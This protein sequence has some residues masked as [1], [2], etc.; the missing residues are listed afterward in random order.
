MT[1]QVTVD[2][3]A[4]QKE[5]LQSLKISFSGDVM[6]EHCPQTIEGV[7]E[8]YRNVPSLIK[9]LNDGKGK[10]L[11]FILYPLQRIAEMFNFELKMKR[12]I[13][14]VSEHIIARIENIFEQIN[15]GKRQFN[16]FLDDI[17]PWEQFI[18]RDWLC[19][20]KEKKL[21]LDGDAL[22]TQREMS[23]LLVEIRSGSAEESKMKELL[24]NFDSQNP[25]SLI[26]DGEVSKVDFI[27]E[28]GKLFP[29]GNPA[30]YCDYA[31]S[32][33]D[34]DKSGTINFSE[35]M[36][37]VAPTQPGD[38]EMRLSVIF[39]VCD[40]DHSG[41]INASEIVKFIEAIEELRGGEAA[42]NTTRA[43]S[44]AAEIMN[45]SGKSKDG[46]VTKEEFIKCSKDNTKISV[47]LLSDIT[48]STPSTTSTTVNDEKSNWYRMDTS[49]GSV[50][51]DDGWARPT[52]SSGQPTLFRDVLHQG[53]TYIDIMTGDYKGYYL[54]GHSQKG[55]GAWSW[56]G[57]DYMEWNNDKLKS[58]SGGTKGHDMAYG[59][60]DRFYFS[61]E[62]PG[63]QDVCVTKVYPY[64]SQ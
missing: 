6:I 28:M 32:T 63:Y 11:T 29:K 47:V 8:A 31:F 13:K 49:F 17:K 53:N 22:K 50:C 19:L 48:D 44:I 2:Y 55:V 20:I 34:A 54:G 23:N 3:D 56:G 9:P 41:T 57:C 16:D 62:K 58:K 4:Q 59:A 39:F 45:S 7:L 5:N 51:M 38:I 35:F 52:P 27:S 30:D 12:N 36:T 40:F 43:K 42:V 46:E 25:C 21:E 1:G 14:E 10:Q 15:A 26:P 60:N 64:K 18:S 24:D 37:A 61:A 33:I